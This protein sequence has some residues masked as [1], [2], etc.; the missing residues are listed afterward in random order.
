[1]F[2]PDI[3][4]LGL[5]N[6]DL[7]IRLKEMPRWENPGMVSGFT[8]ADGGPAGTAC[9]VAAMLDAKT[10]GQVILLKKSERPSALNLCTST[11]S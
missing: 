7:V 1:M 10:P 6:V 5:A 9:A 2:E 4:G 3:I 8:L 11:N